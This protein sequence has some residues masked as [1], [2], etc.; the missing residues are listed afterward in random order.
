M[1]DDMSEPP[2]PPSIQP[3]TLVS[4]VLARWP[5]TAP[6]FVKYRMS[7]IG[8]EMSI[9]EALADAACIYQLDP[10]GFVEEIRRAADVSAAD[11]AIHE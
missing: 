10:A 11:A 9:F 1:L 3:E 7:C 8:C 5:Q 2:P 6:V 4:E